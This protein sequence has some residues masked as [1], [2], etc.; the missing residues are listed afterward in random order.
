ML[1]YSSDIKT[2]LLRHIETNGCMQNVL[3]FRL[4]SIMKSCRFHYREWL[5]TRIKYTLATLSSPVFGNSGEVL[6]T[7]FSY[8]YGNI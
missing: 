5:Y 1:L 6:V 4:K 8:D 7:D 3:R 2:A